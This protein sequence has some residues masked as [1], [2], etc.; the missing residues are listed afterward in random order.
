MPWE[1]EDESILDEAWYSNRTIFGNT[2]VRYKTDGGDG[3]YY[4]ARFEIRRLGNRLIALW[5]SKVEYA[6][7]RY[8]LLE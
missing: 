3:F 8:P 7:P 2:I 5:G 1:W 6:A 4:P